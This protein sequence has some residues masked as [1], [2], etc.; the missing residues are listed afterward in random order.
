MEAAAPYS[1]PRQQ[2]RMARAATTVNIFEQR[3][4]NFDFIRLSM[5]VLVIFSHSY[6]LGLGYETTEPFKLATRGQI[7]GGTIAV[8]SFFILSGFLIAHSFLHSKSLTAYFG[9]RIRR[10]YPAFFVAMIFCAVIVAP[11]SGATSPY[12]S[13]VAR[14]LDFIGNTLRLREFTYRGGFEANPYPNAINGSTW[15]ISY[16]F[17]CYV[18]VALLGILGI[19]RRRNIVQILFWLSI[20]VSFLFARSGWRPGG[21]ILGEIFGFPP[22]WARLLPMY[23]AGVV[24]YLYRDRIPFRAELALAALISLII[25]SFTPFGWTIIFPLAGSYLLFWFSYNRDMPLQNFGHFGDFSY[26]TYLYA[27]PIQQMIVQY[28]GHST[29]PWALFLTSCPL[30]LLFAFAQLAPS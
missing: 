18:G 12:S 1:T 22:F 3:H 5:A 26:G 16:E 23:L 17:W 27:F 8:D 21:K 11:I 7:T 13:Y 25:A 14:M 6:P 29:N 4:N 30:T 19:L 10:I 15:S 24:F 20:A 9:K 28:V 2:T